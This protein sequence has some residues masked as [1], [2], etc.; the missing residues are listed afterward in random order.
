MSAPQQ[1]FFPILRFV[2][3]GVSVNT[4]LY[5]TANLFLH[6]LLLLLYLVSVHCQFLVSPYQKSLKLPPT[7]EKPTFVFIHGIFH[8]ASCYDSLI[9]FL[10]PHGYECVAITHPSVGCKPVVHDFTNDVDFIRKKVQSLSDEGKEII[11]VMHSYGGSMQYFL[12]FP[13]LCSKVFLVVGSSSHTC[14]LLPAP[15]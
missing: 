8:T 14:S 9:T 10:E 11:V 4:E 5:N 13:L 3:N 7:M 15:E 1:F 12:L 2:R 6:P